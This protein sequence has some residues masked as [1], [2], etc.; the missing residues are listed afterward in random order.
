MQRQNIALW[1][2][3]HN[4]G[5]RSRASAPPLLGNVS[6]DSRFNRKKLSALCPG[7]I[8]PL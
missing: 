6:E 3:E 5:G 8:P 7:L 2:D 4:D 1:S